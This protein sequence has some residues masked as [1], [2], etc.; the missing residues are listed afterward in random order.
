M[1]EFGNIGSIDGA[2]ITINGRYPE[3]GYSLNEKSSF[4]IR[5]LGGEG[6]LVG[7]NDKIAVREGDVVFVEK[8]EPY[9]F[10]GKNLLLFMASS[11]AWHPDQY[12]FID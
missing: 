10:E 7:N 5:I 6:L 8:G 9:Y 1:R 12:S 4:V 3:T 11:P 2:D